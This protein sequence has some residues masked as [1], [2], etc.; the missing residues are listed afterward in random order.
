MLRHATLGEETYSNLKQMILTGKYQPGQRLIYDQVSKELGVSQT[1]LKEAFLRLQKEG[2][3]V[4]IAR[5]G[6]YV[7]QFTMSDI[8]EFYQIRE[9]LEGL[10]ARLACEHVTEADI[11]NLRKL[12]DR[13][14]YCIDKGDV[15]QCL[16]MDIRF[17][18]EIVRISGNYRL[19]E[20]MHSFVLTNLFS[21]AGKGRTYIDH[22]SEVIKDHLEVIDA[23][24]N[25]NGILAERVMREQIRSGG[26]WILLK[27]SDEEDMVVTNLA[28]QPVNPT[29]EYL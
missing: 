23:L 18:E 15:A 22:G 21:I 5:K 7:R 16:K 11:K 28:D 8:A 25:R 14:K 24:K 17:H 6:T 2:L 12:C 10:S 19:Q 20:I 29:T 1:P 9:M 27:I 26:E 13:I 4:I 3:V